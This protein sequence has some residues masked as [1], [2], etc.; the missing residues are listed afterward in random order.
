MRNDLYLRLVL[1]VIAA[2]LLY[3]C[4]VLTPLPG[5]HAQQVVG[6]PRPGEYTGPAEVVIVG[7]RAG[8]SGPLPV[9]VAG[10]VNVAGDVKVVNDVRI[11]GRVQ[12]EQVP[13]SAQRVLLVGWENLGS[14]QTPGPSQ[15]FNGAAGVGLPTSET[16]PR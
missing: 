8:Q 13:N 6:A 1:T 4:V 14:P 10:L 7:W 5:V 15:S 3:L 12:A 9:Q 2:A 11:T 16:R